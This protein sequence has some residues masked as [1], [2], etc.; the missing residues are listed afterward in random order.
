VEAQI[1]WVEILNGGFDKV[2]MEERQRT[3]TTVAGCDEM[4]TSVSEK[5]LNIP[6]VKVP[7]R[8]KSC[9]MPLFN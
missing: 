8:H 9:T 7:V 6:P 3:R 1:G 2:G 4:Y 5:G